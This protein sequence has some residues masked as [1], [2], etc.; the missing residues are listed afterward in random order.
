MSRLYHSISIFCLKG[1]VLSAWFFLTV[2]GLQ[3]CPSECI[4]STNTKSEVTAYILEESKVERISFNFSE[5]SIFLLELSEV[6][7]DDS[8]DDKDIIEEAYFKK[9]ID[10]ASKLI[11]GVL[12]HKDAVKFYIRFC[13]LRIHLT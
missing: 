2:T 5:F 7:N 9:D 12:L 10:Y 1:F 8:N 11:S 13:C 6:D 3:S 4:Y